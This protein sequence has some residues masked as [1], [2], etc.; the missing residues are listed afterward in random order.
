MSK[1]YIV[2]PVRLCNP[3]HRKRQDEYVR[4]LESEGHVVH[5]PPRDVDQSNDDGAVRIC[6]AHEKAMLE[7]DEI[8]I[9]FDEMSYG[10]HFDS[11]F[12]VACHK[13]K[14]TKLV[15]VDGLHWRPEKNFANYLRSVI[16][17]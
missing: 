15:G 1:I 10:C 4:F 3:E 14:G 7:A 12:A 16:N 6:R 8:H 11:G 5:H 13:L 9:F 17:G 2:C